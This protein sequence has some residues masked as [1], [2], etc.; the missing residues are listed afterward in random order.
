LSKRRKHLE[1]ERDGSIGKGEARQRKYKKLKL[2]GGRV[3][4]CSSD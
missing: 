1:N 3:Y 4:D 2:G